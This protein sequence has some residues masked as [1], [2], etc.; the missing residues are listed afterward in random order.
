MRIAR[1]LYLVKKVASEVQLLRSAHHRRISRRSVPVATNL[2]GRHNGSKSI[3]QKQIACKRRDTTGTTG[4]G[5]TR[6][7]ALPLERLAPYA[8]FA[9]STL[10]ISPNGGFHLYVRCPL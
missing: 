4:R 1:N 8:A 2:R 5:T 6:G 3:S 7:D 9:S 10:A